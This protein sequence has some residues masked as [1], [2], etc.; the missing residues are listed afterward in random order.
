MKL[1]GVVALVAAVAVPAAVAATAGSTG[2]HRLHA[3]CPSA[4][5]IT[6]LPRWRSGGVLRADVNG[7]GRADTV[8]IRF[9][10]AAPGRCAFYLRVSTARRFYSLKLGRLVGD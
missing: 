10:R 4:K 9:D 8:S 2:A 6:D 7:D 5:R 1:L 3:H